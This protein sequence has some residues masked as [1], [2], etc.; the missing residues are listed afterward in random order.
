[1]GARVRTSVAARLPLQAGH[2]SADSGPLSLRSFSQIPSASG[3][4]STLPDSPI[5]ATS[6]PPEAANA[7]T[8]LLRNHHSL[9]RTF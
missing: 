8:P 7:L 1:M 5:Q 6:I 3:Q 2:Q 4:E 9:H